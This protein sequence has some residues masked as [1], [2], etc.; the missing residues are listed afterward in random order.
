MKRQTALLTIGFLTIPLALAVFAGPA[1]AAPAAGCPAQAV[2]PATTPAEPAAEAADTGTGSAMVKITGTV[3]AGVEFGCLIL[4]ADD[5]GQY[6][7]IGG[8]PRVITVGAILRITG[9]ARNDVASYCMQ[10]QAF[11]VAWVEVLG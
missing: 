9:Y 2:Q 6:L 11:Q 4:K 10:G 8:D 7:L 1:S 3:V 5:G